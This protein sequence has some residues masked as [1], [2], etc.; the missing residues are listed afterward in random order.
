MSSESR[1][2]DDAQV[3]FATLASEMLGGCSVAEQ[4][5]YA[6]LARPLLTLLR[7]RTR[8]RQ[9]AEDLTQ[10]TLVI[11]HERLLADRIEDLSALPGFARQT[12][13]NLL[14]NWSRR[15]GRRQTDVDSSMVEAVATAEAEPL[16]RLL[17]DARRELVGELIGELKR[18]RDREILE[19]LYVWGHDKARIC[20]DLTLR[21]ADVDRIAF[22]ARGRLIDL[23]NRRLKQG[24]F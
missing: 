21:P 5:L 12:A 7:S 20:V 3:S 22:R 4:Q 16:G 1:Q 15:E 10:D 9:L 13:L 24:E 11:V 2:S 6:R 23:A 8:D 14:A 19:R 17:R 18:P